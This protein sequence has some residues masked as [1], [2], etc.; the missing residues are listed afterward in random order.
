M[1]QVEVDPGKIIGEGGFGN[2]YAS[3]CKKYAF[4]VYKA[5][6]WDYK[7]DRKYLAICQGHPNIVKLFDIHNP[8]KKLVIVMELAECD[9][10]MYRYLNNDI[11]VKAIGLQLFKGLD[12]IHS[13]NI[14]H[15][16]IKESNMLVFDGGKRVAITDFGSANRL[17]MINF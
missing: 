7:N 2:V 10:R 4:K 8:K 15:R 12:F 1:D 9:L 6:N 17:D 5:K 11:P 16:D 13:K 14:V 3:E